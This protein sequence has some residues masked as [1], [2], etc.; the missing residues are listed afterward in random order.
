MSKQTK[1]DAFRYF[2]TREDFLAR[3]CFDPDSDEP[4]YG[5]IVDDEAE[6]CEFPFQEILD[7]GHE[8]S[9]KRARR[10]AKRLGGTL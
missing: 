6:W 9:M 7:G 3:V 10:T 8:I 4:V 5:Q 2:M 1:A